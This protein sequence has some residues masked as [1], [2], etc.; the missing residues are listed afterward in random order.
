MNQLSFDLLSIV[1]GG[2][3]P[4]DFEISKSQMEYWIKNQLADKIK[5]E[6]WKGRAIPQPLVTDLGCITME[7]VD[8][9]EC[10]D[11]DINCSIRRTAVDVP[12]FVKLTDG[13][14]ITR[15]GPIDKI[16]IPYNIISYERA[17]Y[18]GNQMFGNNPVFAFW[19][20]ERIYLVSKHAAKIS[21]LR[22]INVQGVLEDFTDAKGFTTCSGDLCY[23]DD[24]PM[25]ITRDMIDYIKTA[26]L[27]VNLEVFL[28][29]PEDNTNDASGS[30]T[31]EETQET[32]V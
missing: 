3:L 1:S 20:D 12:R 22:K 16:K 29:A 31:V 25:P 17:P 19:K 2:S 13:M 4:D 11:I 9:A 24:S 23:T 28:K 6:I 8:R 14:A 7:S 10:C 26:V 32:R 21:M 15:I 30:N 18:V 5:Q 27:K